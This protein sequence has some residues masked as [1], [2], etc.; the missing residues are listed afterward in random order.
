MVDELTSPGD[1]AVGNEMGTGLLYHT[2]DQVEQKG[3][4]ANCLASE[5]YMMVDL[6]QKDEFNMSMKHQGAGQDLNILAGVHKSYAVMG[7]GNRI[8]QCDFR[9]MIQIRD[10]KHGGEELSMKR[11][12]CVFT[13]S[14]DADPVW[15]QGGGHAEQQP[16]P[17]QHR[18]QAV[19]GQGGHGEYGGDLLGNSSLEPAQ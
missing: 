12:G 4:L 9:E 6:N 15:P 11:S 13:N 14:G 8:T 19:G 3:I 1:I 18:L 5:E 16:D 17:P 10:D 7:A 2:A